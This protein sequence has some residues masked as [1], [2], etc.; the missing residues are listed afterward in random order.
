MKKYTKKIEFRCP[1]D[2]YIWYKKLAER[3]DIILSELLRKL[4][5][6]FDELEGINEPFLIIKVGFE[7][8]DKLAWLAGN[9]DEAIKEREKA[10][11]RD[12][13]QANKDCKITKTK[14]VFTDKEIS[15]RYCIQKWN[16]KKFNCVCKDLGLKIHEEMFY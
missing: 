8:I 16:G 5:E 14:R 15:D 4:P 9:P 1:Q 2:I 12:I 6:M 3:E 11:K 13:A 7:G 10:I